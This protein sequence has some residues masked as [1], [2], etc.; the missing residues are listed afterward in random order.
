MIL[1]FVLAIALAAETS[2]PSSAFRI[3]RT[4]AI[5]AELTPGGQA[6]PTAAAGVYLV[7]S[8]EK[9]G[10][11]A[12]LTYGELRAALSPDNS[13]L[14]AKLVASGAA[15]SGTSRVQT[16]DVYTPGVGG[17]TCIHAHFDVLIL[18]VPVADG[19]QLELSARREDESK[20]SVANDSCPRP[21]LGE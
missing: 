11:P 13:R 4:P 9:L 18:S 12:L 17:T 8:A 16:E 6:I 3:I 7:L 14:A 15:I 21:H 5:E 19:G 20:R 1:A 2:V 10:D